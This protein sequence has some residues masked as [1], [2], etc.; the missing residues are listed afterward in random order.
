M[1]SAVFGARCC[2]NRMELK[3]MSKTKIPDPVIVN[4]FES[5]ED[6]PVRMTGF[7]AGR[8]SRFIGPS[9]LKIIQSINR[10]HELSRNKILGK[11]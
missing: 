4:R 6:M 10:C 3:A 2:P 9:E 5:A 8:V 7:Q 11:F 1:E